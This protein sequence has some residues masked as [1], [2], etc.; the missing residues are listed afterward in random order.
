MFVMDTLPWEHVPLEGKGSRSRMNSW[1]LVQLI[2]GFRD[3]VA[4]L[5]REF[6]DVQ[7]CALQPSACMPAI[8]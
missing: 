4:V 3:L 2:P 1:M 8:A 7:G 6:H 5:Q